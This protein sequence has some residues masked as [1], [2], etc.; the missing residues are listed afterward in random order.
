MVPV[1]SIPVCQKRPT[2]VKRGLYNSKKIYKKE[3]Y[4]KDLHEPRPAHGDYYVKSGLHKSKETYRSQKRPI[5]VKR[6]L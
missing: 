4:E 5:E 2:K 3:T 1:M 6:D